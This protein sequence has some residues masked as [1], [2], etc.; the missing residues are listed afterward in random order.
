MAKRAMWEGNPRNY[1]IFQE[2]RY[3]GEK[4]YRIY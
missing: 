2:V 4:S 3:H 1:H